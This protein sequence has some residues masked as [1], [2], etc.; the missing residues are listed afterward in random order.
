MSK[1]SGHKLLPKHC[2]F[3][4]RV[5]FYPCSTHKVALNALRQLAGYHSF[6]NLRELNHLSLG[7]KAAV[8]ILNRV[9]VIA[10]LAL[11]SKPRSFDSK[12]FL[13]LPLSLSIYPPSHLSIY[14]S[15]SHTH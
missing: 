15:V 6:E 4:S 3:F 1:S 5:A 11:F 10:S 12:A 9:S 14:L 8:H 13:I 7:Y 2:F